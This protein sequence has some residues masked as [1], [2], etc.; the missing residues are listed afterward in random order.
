MSSLVGFTMQLLELGLVRR[1]LGCLCE[2]LPLQSGV[3][4]V[5]T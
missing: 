4:G 3:A 5:V 2:Y 1:E